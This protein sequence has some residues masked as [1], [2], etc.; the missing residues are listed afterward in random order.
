[1]SNSHK[2]DSRSSYHL[3]AGILLATILW[4]LNMGHLVAVGRS[5]KCR[6][7]LDGSC[8]VMDFSG[9]GTEIKQ[10]WTRKSAW[11]HWLSLAHISWKIWEESLAWNLSV[12]T[13]IVFWEC[14]VPHSIWSL[15]P[16]G[17]TRSCS[18]IKRCNNLNLFRWFPC[19]ICINKLPCK[20]A[21]RGK[22]VKVHSCEQNTCLLFNM[23]SEMV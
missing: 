17:R 19:Y 12:P 9:L 23:G 2:G 16:V 6:A 5:S 4:V 1:M 7:H 11:I 13:F 15:E 21:V 20:A 8:G 14:R 10:F 3:V 22:L 18:G